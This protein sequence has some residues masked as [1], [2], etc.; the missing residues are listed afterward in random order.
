MGD[1]LLTP[2]HLVFLMLLAVLLF[3]S[4][5][6]PEIGRSLGSGLRE[7]K[8][9]VSGMTDVKDALDGVQEVRAAVSPTNLAGTFVPGV[10]EVQQSVSVAK[11]LVNPLAGTT[12]AKAETTGA[13]HAAGA[14]TAGAG[15]T[16][17]KAE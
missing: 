16:A 15:G 2:T 14:E 3:G 7:F 13:S 9:S 6:L 4:R 8:Q 11:D 10:K 12:G 17:P 1:S 5:R